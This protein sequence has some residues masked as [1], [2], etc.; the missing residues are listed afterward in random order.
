MPDQHQA[1]QGSDTTPSRG[2]GMPKTSLEASTSPTVSEAPAVQRK[3]HLVLNSKGG[4][5]KS[6]ASGLIAEFLRDRG[7]PL[8]CLDTDAL[9]AT[10]RDLKALN[11]EPVRVF[12]E[13]GDAVD[14]QSIDGMVERFLTEDA[15]FVVDSGASVFVPLSQHLVNDA[16]VSALEER[17]KKMVVHA[18]VAGGPELLHCA[19]G[20]DS[21]ARQYPAGVDMVLWLNEFHGSTSGNGEAF[22]QTRVFKTHEQRISGII[23]LNRLHPTTYGANLAAMLARGMTFAEADRSPEF[24]TMT[25]QRLRQIQ[26]PLWEQLSAVL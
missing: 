24:F 23:R 13:D 9:N 7:E 25:K 4:I 16:V 22:E 6:F 15:S 3:V 18:I 21:M 19:R 11:V 1:V 20:L 8:V 5:G 14:I 26:R 17:G 2:R 12:G 10:F